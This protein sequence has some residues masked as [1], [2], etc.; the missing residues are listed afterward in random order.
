MNKLLLIVLLL[1]LCQIG[2][3]QNESDRKINSEEVKILQLESPVYFPQMPM[4]SDW[5]QPLFINN[6]PLFTLPQYLSFSI[7]ET[8]QNAV[9]FGFQE[10]KYATVAKNLSI[11]FSEKDETY[12]GMGSVYVAQ[13]SLVW[14][15]GK[16]LTF[17][18]ATFLNKQY[19]PMNLSP[20]ISYG[21]SSSI[22]YSFNENVQLNI[23]GNYLNKNP[24]DPFTNMN[25]LFTQS[26][27]G[28]NITFIKD[29]SHKIGFGMDHQFN[30]STKQWEPVY[31]THIT[32]KFPGR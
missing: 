20:I 21:V 17:T 29:E 2:K 14:K 28:S 19:T 31:G 9:D 10:L 11:Y 30:V 6:K 27:V 18:G 23:Y 13:A 15:A 12:S 22:Q 25:S 1:L 3:T 32:Y 26:K 24:D 8:K 5:Q 16:R 7:Y 4:L